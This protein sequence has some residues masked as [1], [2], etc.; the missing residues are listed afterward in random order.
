MKKIITL[1]LVLLSSQLSAKIVEE[2]ITYQHQKVQLTGYLYYDNKIT[3]KKPLVLVAHEWWGLNDYAKERAK[4][5]AKL[6]YVGFA[7]DMYGSGKQTKHGKQA[8]D[9]VQAVKKNKDFW[10]QRALKALIVGKQHPQVNP[11][12]TAAIG[13]CFGGATVMQMAYA[14]A[15]LDAVVSFHGSLIPPTKPQLNVIKA[16]ILVNNGAAD[17]FI[18]PESINTWQ[19]TMQQSN[20][21]WVFVNYANAKHAFTNPEAAKYAAINSISNLEYDKKADKRSWQLMQDFL[22]ESFTQTLSK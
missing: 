2:K 19:H 12:Q 9:W 14:G 4:S 15:E 6:G 7:I 22:G 5:L 1:L 17:S 13:Y 20:V 21:D 8:K 10:Q 11:N 3:A 16:R 18:S